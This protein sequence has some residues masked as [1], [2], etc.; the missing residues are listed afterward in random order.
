[1]KFILFSIIIFS[2][3]AFGKTCDKRVEFSTGSKINPEVYKCP[4]GS[5]SYKQ[6]KSN[7]VPSTTGTVLRFM[8]GINAIPMGRNESYCGATAAVNVHNAYCKKYF[9]KPRV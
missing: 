6:I 5:V 2:Y 9:V 3:G 7:F 8:T 4:D 1:M